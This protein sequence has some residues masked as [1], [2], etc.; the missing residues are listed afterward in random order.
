MSIE[1]RTENPLTPENRHLIEASQAAMLEVLPPEEIFSFSAEELATP[2]TQFLVAR[3]DGQA[4]GCVALVD[5]GR[6]GEVKRLFVP[7]EARGLGLGRALMAAL[8]QAAKD[9]GLCRLRLET[10]HTLT[11]AVELYRALGFDDCPAFGG[12]PDIASNLF[13]EK[14]VGVCVN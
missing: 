5:Q 6:Y 10:G 8:E 1:I 3:V 14:T 9:I 13:M 12:Y 4:Q 7:P 11:A 2:N